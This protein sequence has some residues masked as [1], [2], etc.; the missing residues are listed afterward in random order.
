MRPFLLMDSPQRG[1]H[2][3]C[4]IQQQ[5]KQESTGEG[6]SKMA[7]GILITMLMLFGMIGMAMFEATNVDKSTK[8]DATRK[9]HTRMMKKAA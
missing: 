5:G 8:R 7:W 3:D 1:W 4:S 9:S 6:V 2:S